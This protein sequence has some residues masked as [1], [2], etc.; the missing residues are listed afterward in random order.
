VATRYKFVELSV[1]TE[2]SLERTVNDWVAK[3][4]QLDAIRFVVGEGSRRPQMAF[5][6]FVRDEAAV[7]ADE[8]PTLDSLPERSSLRRRGP[9]IIELGELDP[10]EIAP[11]A[12][13]LD[14]DS[15]VTK[16]GR[17]AAKKKTKKKT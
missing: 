8:T 12:A 16:P 17:P 13:D 6:S 15:A 3:G 7:D 9:R 4:W 5:V 14:W 11:Y 1:V 2:E 10:G